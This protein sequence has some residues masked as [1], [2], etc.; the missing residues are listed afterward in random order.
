MPQYILT[1]RLLLRPFTAADGPRVVA[2]LDDFAVSKW[3][4]KVPHPFTVS[5]LKLVNSDGS[6]RWPQLAAITMDG[7]IVGGISSGDHF[8]YWIGQKYWGQGIAT[9]AATAM[10]SSIFENDKRD[11]IVSGCF[12]GNPASLKILSR[13]GFR[14]TSRDMVPCA[15]RGEGIEVANINLQLTRDGWGQS[16]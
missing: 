11:Q 1:E 6:S 13:L 8:G 3:L 4:A 16:L 15:A 9:E 2:L 10:L 14:E 12:S 7:E 5:D